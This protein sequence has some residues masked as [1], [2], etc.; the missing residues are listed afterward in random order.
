MMAMASCL[1][2][3]LVKFSLQDFYPS[4]QG[5]SVRMISW[6]S[7]AIQNYLLICA[8]QTKSKAAVASASIATSV[9]VRGDAPMVSPEITWKLIR[10]VLTFQRQ[11]NGQYNRRNLT[12]DSQSLFLGFIQGIVLVFIL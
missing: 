6:M 11:F 5:M 9:A 12:S 7:I 10:P 1:S 8:I 2:P 3:T 4:P